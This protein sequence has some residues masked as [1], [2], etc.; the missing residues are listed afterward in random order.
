MTNR[1]IN[2]IGIIPARAGSKGIPGKN[3]K[4][5]CG[6]PLLAYT[7]N[8]AKKSRYLSDIILSTDSL[9]IA[10]IG[11]KFGANVPYLRSTG[12]A[13]D[14]ISVIPTL[15]DCLKNAEKNYKTN[16]DFIIMLQPTTPLRLVDDIDNALELLFE[17]DADSII[18]VSPVI[19]HPYYMYYLDRDR[20]V[21]PLP[22]TKN[23]LNK[24]RQE[25]PQ[26]YIRNGAIYAA[27][28][29]FFKRMKYIYD[30]NSIVSIMPFERSIN[31]N[32]EVDWILAEY[33]LY[34]R[35]KICA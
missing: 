5:L 30:E 27:K 16:M 31:I 35:E 18:S 28:V 25:F 6:L 17:K 33:F 34:R 32:D 12:L 19:Q 8:E 22:D 10:E 13:T 20:K 29:D 23:S 3:I 9:E 1:N 15:L 14:N 2:I 4:L 21:K 7:I 11:R 26:I 24:R